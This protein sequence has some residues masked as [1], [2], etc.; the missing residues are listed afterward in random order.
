MIPLDWADRIAK[1]MDMG[2][3]D[4]FVAMASGNPVG[5]A[6]LTSD[7][8]TWAA[9]P[10][11]HL[12]CLYVDEEYRNAGVGRLL[13]DAVI[14][15]AQDQGFDELQWQT[16]AWNAKAIRFYDRLGGKQQAKQRFSLT[17]GEERGGYVF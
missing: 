12:D 11:G 8:E 15:Y 6:A 17:L 16:P 10:Y 1:L 7:V 14:L 3:L 4:L 9:S 13:M 2:R 5:Y